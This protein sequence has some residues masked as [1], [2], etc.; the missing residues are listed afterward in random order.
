MGVISDKIKQLTDF[1]VNKNVRKTILD[2]SHIIC[3]MNTQS[4]LFEKGE[5]ADGVPIASF[6]PYAPF[7][8][9]MKKI[10]NQPYDRV[11]LRDE[12]DFYESFS[13]RAD[14]DKFDITASNWKTADLKRG[15][16]DN[17]MGLNA[18][19]RHELALR[20]VLPDL[21]QALIKQLKTK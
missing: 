13:V 17:I 8:I 1:D 21:K 18:E 11:T 3:D 5:N 10:K 12:G 15:Y 20:Y 4:Q 19:N 14:I 6:A 2:Y 9:E 16:G 7:T